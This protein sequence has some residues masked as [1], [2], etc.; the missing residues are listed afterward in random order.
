MQEL[1]RDSTAKTMKLATMIYDAAE[2]LLKS[3]SLKVNLP[4]ARS[5]DEG[6]CQI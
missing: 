5:F 2:S 6:K 1:P 4:E 3:H